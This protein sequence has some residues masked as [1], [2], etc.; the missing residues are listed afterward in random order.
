MARTI[1]LTG[2]IG[3]GKSTVTALLR[4]RGVT[5]LDADAAVRELQRRGGEGLRR[6]VDAFGP[7]ILTADGELDRSALG[8]VVF[9]DQAA[10]RRVEAILHPLV[11]RRLAEEQEAAERRGATVVVQDIPL[12]FE[13][14]NRASFDETILVYAPP[15]MQRRRLVELRGMR[16]A[17]ADARIESQMPM[18]E[19]R[20]LATHIIENTGS[21]EELRAAVDRVWGEVTGQPDGPRSGAGSQV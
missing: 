21:L 7:E 2:G 13:S 11:R 19:K 18:E 9:S 6:L 12:L 16:P 14:R 8:R 5:V 4:E 15:E 3:S 17:D 10:R 20:R 1:G